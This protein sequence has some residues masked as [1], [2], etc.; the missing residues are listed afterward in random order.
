LAPVGN[1]GDKVLEIAAKPGYKGIMVLPTFKMSAM[2]AYYV[3]PG[4]H[5]L[6]ELMQDVASNTKSTYYP[7]P[8]H[9]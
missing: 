9:T 3:T 8:L 2:N 5:D 6:P 7:T 1:T 4:E